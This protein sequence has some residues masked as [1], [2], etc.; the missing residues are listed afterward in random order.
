[1]A[2]IQIA[3]IF[4]FN[5]SQSDCLHTYNVTALLKWN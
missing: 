3:P 5:K 1:M 4:H 2:Q